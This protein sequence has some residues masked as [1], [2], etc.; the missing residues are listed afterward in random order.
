MLSGLS[1]LIEQKK[2]EL[3]IEELKTR[4]RV[5]PEEWVLCKKYIDGMTP[6]YM[7][8]ANSA[9]KIRPEDV[10]KKSG[11]KTNFI[12]IFLPAFRE[13]DASLCVIEDKENKAVTKVYYVSYSRELGTAY[14]K[15][16]V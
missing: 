7:E 4:P 9:I 2:K 10:D 3:Y 6:N 12:R 16:I 8:I 14:M 5:E 1:D 13:F 15:T 11:S